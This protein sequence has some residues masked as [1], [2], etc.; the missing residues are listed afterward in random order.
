VCLFGL[1]RVESD[2]SNVGSERGS[3]RRIEK[4][5]FYLKFHMFDLLKCRIKFILQAKLI[6]LWLK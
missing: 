6:R 4:F 1:R 3:F 2:N 5:T